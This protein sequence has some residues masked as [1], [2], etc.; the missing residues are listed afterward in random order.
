MEIKIGVRNAPR[1]LVVES[2]L[3]PDAVR[4]L[5]GE[6]L[7][8]GKVLS[9]TDDRGRTVH[10]PAE[11]LAYVEVGAAE[12]TLCR[13]WNDFFNRTVMPPVRIAD[14]TMSTVSQAS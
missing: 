7:A 13:E 12:S 9:L 1:E 2:G 6:A 8:G 5:V 4:D 11:A 10:V 3:T 14:F